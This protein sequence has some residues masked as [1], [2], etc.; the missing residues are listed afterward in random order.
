[1]RKYEGKITEQE[2]HPSLL[3]V[4]QNGTNDNIFGFSG[5]VVI[6]EPTTLARLPLNKYNKSTD[7]IIILKNGTLIREGYDFNFNANYTGIIRVDGK[8]WNNNPQQTTKFEFVIYK[9]I[10]SFSKHDKIE[11]INGSISSE[12]IHPDIT[13]KL[14][15]PGGKKGSFLIKANSNDYEYKWLEFN[16]VSILL[17]SRITI[18]EPIECKFINKITGDSFLYQINDMNINITNLSAGDY[19]LYIFGNHKVKPEFDKYDV[20]VVPNSQTSIKVN[21]IEKDHD[22]QITVISDIVLTDPIVQVKSLTSDNVYNITVAGIG[23]EISTII[24]LKTDIYKVDL[25]ENDSVKQ[26]GEYVLDLTDTNYFSNTNVV[27]NTTSRF[28]QLELD[29][30]LRPLLES[31]EGL[32]RFIAVKDIKDNDIDILNDD[33]SFNSNLQNLKE[34]PIEIRITDI[35]NGMEDIKYIKSPKTGINKVMRVYLKANTRYKV[36]VNIGNGI[37]GFTGLNTYKIIE[38]DTTNIQHSCE[39]FEDASILKFIPKADTRGMFKDSKGVVKN[40]YNIEIISANNSEF[41]SYR[42]YKIIRNIKADTLIKVDSDMYYKLRIIPDNKTLTTQSAYARGDVIKLNMGGNIFTEENSKPLISIYT[43]IIEYGF[44]IDPTNSDSNNCVTYIE[45]AVGF[46]PARRLSSGMD[47]GSWDKSFILNS[48]KPVILTDGVVTKELNKE[49]QSANYNNITINDDFMGDF[50]V[51]F[52]KCYYKFLEDLNGVIE[53]RICTVKKDDSYTAAAFT[54]HSDI[55]KDYFYYGMY[56]ATLIND[57]LRSLP[58]KEIVVNKSIRELYSLASSRGMEYCIEDYT[59]RL[60]II[61]LLTLISKSLDSQLSFGNGNTSS[62]V[63]QHTGLSESRNSF[64]S[65]NLV[66]KTF[67]IE[68]FWG[69]VEKFMMGLLYNDGSFRFKLNAPYTANPMNYIEADVT[70]PPS[71]NIGN[72]NI[73]KKCTASSFGFLPQLTDAN[74][75]YYNDLGYISNNFPFPS[76]GGS[77]TSNNFAGMW[78]INVFYSWGEG[79]DKIGARLIYI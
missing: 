2:L 9:N 47:F 23:K 70:V 66:I 54:N 61:C 72:N 48:I 13:K 49:T 73:I 78:N 65:D 53:F 40:Y 8:K 68:N 4:L 71:N 77:C 1:M 35:L 26:L 38:P 36:T 22:V 11:F 59:R 28:R 57:N 44:R 45:D 24:Q 31:A 79:S 67:F 51:Q 50:M 16:N 55:E 27:I 5:Q 37:K 42:T 12:K 19:E 76:V 60:Y 21:M 32:S 14:I 25:I 7:I 3:K 39:L 56:E 33:I 18:S 10:K 46:V 62:G 43:P 58:G 20:T 29:L 64:Y 75:N 34:I 41:E 69:N 6:K 63:I 30:T 52:E 17:T 15:P 74:I